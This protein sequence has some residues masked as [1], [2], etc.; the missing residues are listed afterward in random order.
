MNWIL[1][2]VS[3]VYLKNFWG[4]KGG[5][6]E[7]IYILD[8]FKI[9]LFSALEQVKQEISSTRVIGHLQHLQFDQNWKKIFIDICLSPLAS[10]YFMFTSIYRGGFLPLVQVYKLTHK[11]LRLLVNFGYYRVLI[12]LMGKRFFPMNLTIST[13]SNYGPN[14]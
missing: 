1:L 5:W 14:S 8:P 7:I 3:L 6:Y 10:K 11:L 13:N 9:Y 12:F 4:D 2:V